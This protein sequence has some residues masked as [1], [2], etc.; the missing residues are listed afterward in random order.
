[1]PRRKPCDKTIDMLDMLNIPTI[2]D[3]I[4]DYEIQSATIKGKWSLI[5]S[6]A[7]KKDGRSREQIAQSM[8]EYLGQP[9]KKSMLDAW[10]SQGRDTH[11]IPLPMLE[12][13]IFVTGNKKPV[14]ALAEIID[15]K[16]IPRC[17]EK[18][19]KYAQAQEIKHQA[20]KIINNY[21]KE[22]SDD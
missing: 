4:E 7:L 20:E 16:A 3:G 8:A 1:M 19:L 10:S 22:W 9:V 18:H 14:N 21:N 5:V 11:I 17:Y 6:A 12:A 15:C 2:D 13:L